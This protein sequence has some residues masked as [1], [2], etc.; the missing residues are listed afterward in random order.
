MKKT[1][2]QVVV[3]PAAGACV[4]AALRV[5]ALHPGVERLAV[6]LCG[7]NVDLPQLKEAL[8]G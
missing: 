1:Y 6:V 2:S 4:A 3:E 8:T 5:K 7:G